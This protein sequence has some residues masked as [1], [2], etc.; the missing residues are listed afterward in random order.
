ML[1]GARHSADRLGA[2]LERPH[3]R[4]QSEPVGELGGLID[5]G[6]AV[7]TEVAADDLRLDPVR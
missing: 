6:V 2:D 4:P 3:L 7:R 5:G 1:G